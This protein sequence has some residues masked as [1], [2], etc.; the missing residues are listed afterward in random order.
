[1]ESCGEDRC[2][3]DLAQE[4]KERGRWPDCADRGRNRAKR[5]R[6]AEAATVIGLVTYLDGGWQCDAGFGLNHF[7]EE[8]GGRTPEV[9]GPI[10][11]EDGE[12]DTGNVVVKERH[13]IKGVVTPDG[14]LVASAVN[15]QSIV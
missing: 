12:F 4:N 13:A 2:R 5:N 8:A 3:R 15:H 11:V 9:T 14:I 6:G 7:V 1:M 10:L